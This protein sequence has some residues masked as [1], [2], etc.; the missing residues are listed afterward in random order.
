MNQKKLCLLLTALLIAACA[1][2]PVF[3][4]G[5]KTFYVNTQNGGDLNLRESPSKNSKSLI[6]I[7]F[8][9]KLEI[10]DLDKKKEWGYC[11]YKDKTGWVMMSFLSE[12]KPDPSNSKAEKAVQD[13]D[14]M[15]AEFRAMNSAPL[16]EPYQI[17][18]RTAKTTTA[19]HLR[20]APYLSAFSMRNDVM[21]GE[22]FT[23]TAEGR[24]WLQVIDN[25]SGRM[26]YVVKSITQ[27][28]VDLS[29]Q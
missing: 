23:V 9:T 15:N 22:V 26:A 17:V 4:M 19:Y 2:F 24:N 11:S 1:V 14:T 21:N 28:Y 25:R 18:I 13:M 7:P 3:A 10:V 29:V 8:G 20:W 16:A 5:T 12:E 6:K 27:P